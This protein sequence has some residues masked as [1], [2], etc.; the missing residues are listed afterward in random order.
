MDNFANIKHWAQFLKR[1]LGESSTV[2]IGCINS[3]LPE[4]EQR[5]GVYLAGPQLGEVAIYREA[6]TLCGAILLA[7]Q[8]YLDQ[9]DRMFAAAKKM[10]HEIALRN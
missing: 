9:Q 8:T 6:P 5:W 4:H 3:Q 2:R 10:L 7:L 1:V